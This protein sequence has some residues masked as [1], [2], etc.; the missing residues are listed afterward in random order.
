MKPCNHPACPNLVPLRTRYCEA[1]AT[2]HRKESDKAY[3]SFQRGNDPCLANAADIRSS[4]RWRNVRR[5]KLA[6]NPLCEDP[7]GDHA[8]LG[9]T[10]TAREVHHI[11]SLQ[12]DPDLAYVM[13]N[14]MALCSRC[15]ARLSQDERRTA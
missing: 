12:T 2:T 11:V 1:H 15:H 6:S 3:D 13:D 7:H 14:L 9:Q 10:V 5:Y 8:K 4:Q